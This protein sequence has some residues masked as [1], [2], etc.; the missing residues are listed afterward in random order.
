VELYFHFPPCVFVVPTETASTLPYRMMV[1]LMHL[2]AHMYRDNFSDAVN[3]TV[4]LCA[5]LLYVC[6]FAR[7]RFRRLLCAAGLRPS[8]GQEG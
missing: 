4:C 2:G 7:M 8:A 6:V 3:G 5:V 1:P